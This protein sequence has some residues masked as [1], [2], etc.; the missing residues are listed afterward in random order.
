LFEVFVFVGF[1]HGFSIL[2]RCCQQDIEDFRGASGD[3]ARTSIP[4]GSQMQPDTLTFG[5]GNSI[6]PKYNPLRP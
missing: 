3:P 6:A 4:I 5:C 2:V 1:S